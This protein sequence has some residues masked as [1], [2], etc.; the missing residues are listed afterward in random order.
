MPRFGKWVSTREAKWPRRYSDHSRKRSGAAP[1]NGTSSF[2]SSPP[3]PSW[4]CQ[5]TVAATDATS[6]HVNR[7]KA[8]CSLQTLRF[9][10]ESRVCISHWPRGRLCLYPV[11]KNDLIN[12]SMALL[13]FCCGRQ[14]RHEAR[15]FPGYRKRLLRCCCCLLSHFSRVRLCAT[16]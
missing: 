11:C 9:N 8:S 5:C 15:N 1:E 14:T 7:V 10:S 3:A 16:P 13:S 6:F 4:G 2:A 12:C